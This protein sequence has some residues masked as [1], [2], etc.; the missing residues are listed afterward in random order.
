MN[1]YDITEQELQLMSAIEDADGEI[2]PEIEEMLAI[3]EENFY[4]KM[5]GYRNIILQTNAMIDAAKKEKERITKYIESKNRLIETLSERGK[6]AMQVFQVDK[7]EFQNGVGGKM[8]L[9][10]S[11]KTII[12]DEE[13]FFAHHTDPEL[14]GCVSVKMSVNKTAVKA[15]IDDG[16]D[17]P[18]HQEQNFS[19]QVK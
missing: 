7:V 14:D 3:N 12:D 10:K 9:R 16:V 15:L 17:V 2:T 6:T 1:L 13:Y 18:A 4:Q 8:S 19:L 5:E 11:N